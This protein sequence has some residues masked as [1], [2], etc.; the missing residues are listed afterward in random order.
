MAAKKPA[1]IDIERDSVL[2]WRCCDKLCI[3]GLLDDARLRCE[4][5][6]VPVTA[7]AVVFIATAAAHLYCSA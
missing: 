4:R 7:R 1:G 5:T 6:Q 2:Q 3:S